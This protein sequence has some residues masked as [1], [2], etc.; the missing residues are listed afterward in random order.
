M[1]TPS[2]TLFNVVAESDVT[3]QDLT[4]TDASEGETTDGTA[5]SV[6]ASVGS[7]EGITLFRITLIDFPQAVVVGSHVDLLNMLQCTISYDDNY[8]SDLGCTAVSISGTQTNIAQCVLSYVGSNS[9]S[10]GV[11]IGGCAYPKVTDTQ[12]TGFETGIQIKRTGGMNAVGPSFSGINVQ[13]MG[14]CVQFLAGVYDACFVDCTFQ[15]TPA[16]L[17]PDVAGISIVGSDGDENQDFDTIR[18]TS[19]TVVG[20]GLYGLEINIGQN[21]QVNGGSFSGNGTAG[22]AILGDAAE[23]Q[24]T[25]ANCIGT[26]ASTGTTQDYGIYVTA[27]QDIQ[28]VGVNCSGNGASGIE[29]D[30]VSLTSVQDVRIIGSICENSVLGGSLQA[31]G[32]SV[33]GASGV[34]I[35]GCTLTGNTAFAAYLSFVENVTVTA[36]DL[37][38]AES[39]AKGVFVGGSTDLP[40]TYVFIRGCNGAQLGGYSDFLA[41]VGNVSH[42]EV[43]DC[44][45]YNDQQAILAN[46][47]TAPSGTFSGITVNGYNGPTAFYLAATGATVTID[48]QS[49]HLSSGGFTLAPGETGQISGGSVTHFLMVGK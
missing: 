46:S 48:S 1:L 19:C 39:G 24:I 22:I 30:G 5:F 47:V 35:D 2:S 38:S 8:A 44:A 32:I 26:C 6:T 43:T 28:L 27:G 33:Y 9:E 14:S 41:V 36:S 29:I 18:F 16:S 40:T 3:F 4:V 11:S 21:I 49:T 23:I 42:L 12:V 25:G 10:F 34:L 7:S 20:Y 45:G 31:Y 17:P 13:A 15:P 37:D